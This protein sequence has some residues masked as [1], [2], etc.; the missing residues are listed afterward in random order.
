M[1]DGETG[2]LARDGASFAAA[3]HRVL[4]DPVFRDRLG[5]AALARASELTWGAT[6]RGTL[7][8]LAAEALRRRPS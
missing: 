5:A 8:V 7:E 3:L 2:L 1:R 4:A 6:A